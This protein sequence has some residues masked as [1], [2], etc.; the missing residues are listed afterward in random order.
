MAGSC[1]ENGSDKASVGD[2]LH[3]VDTDEFIIKADGSLAQMGDTETGNTS[4]LRAPSTTSGP[5]IGP[6]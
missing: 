1:P 3:F 5:T 6:A 4:Y 2:G